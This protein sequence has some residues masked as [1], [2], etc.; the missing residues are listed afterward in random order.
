[1]NR[2]TIEEYVETLDHQTISEAQE[3]FLKELDNFIDK[4]R[5]SVELRKYNSTICKK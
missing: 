3:E 5:R 1:M 2:K 4:I